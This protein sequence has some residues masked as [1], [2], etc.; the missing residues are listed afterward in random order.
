[1]VKNM[2]RRGIAPPL[3]RPGKM[4]EKIAPPYRRS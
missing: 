3:F 2:L 4:C 1:M